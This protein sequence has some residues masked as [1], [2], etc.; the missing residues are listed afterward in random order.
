VLLD[1]ILE[2]QLRSMNTIQYKGDEYLFTEGSIHTAIQALKEV[3]FDG[4]IRTNETR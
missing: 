2:K 3:L 4:L 1:G